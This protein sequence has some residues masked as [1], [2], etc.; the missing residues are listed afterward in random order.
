VKL[1][2]KTGVTLY[3]LSGVTL[4]LLGLPLAGLPFNWEGL[5]RWI[6]W[7]L[8]ALPVWAGMFSVPGCGSALLRSNGASNSFQLARWERASLWTGLAAA[9]AGVAGGTMTILFSPPALVC[10]IGNMR[11]LWQADREKLQQPK[12]R[13]LWWSR[14]AVLVVATMAVTLWGLFGSLL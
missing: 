9:S 14:V 1:L 13:L 8:L 4:C 12:D 3:V 2:R 5:A 10:A 6:P 11:M 7:M